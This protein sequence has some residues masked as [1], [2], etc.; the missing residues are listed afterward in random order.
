MAHRHHRIIGRHDGV[1]AEVGLE[2]L[3]RLGVQEALDAPSR[4]FVEADDAAAAVVV[5][6]APIVQERFQDCGWNAALLHAHAGVSGER[7]GAHGTSNRSGFGGNSWRQ[8]T[9]AQAQGV[10]LANPAAAPGKEALKA[11]KNIA[12]PESRAQFARLDQQHGEDMKVRRNAIAVC[13]TAALL[14]VPAA[15]AVHGGA[16][17]VNAPDIKWGDAPPSLPKGAKFTVLSGDPG[18]AGLVHARLQMPAKYKIPAH[19]HSSAEDVT[20]ISGTL[21]LGEGDKLDEKAAHEMKVGAFHSIPPKAHHYAFTKTGAVV[22]I[23]VMGPFDITYIDPKDDPSKAAAPAKDAKAPA[24]D[25][26]K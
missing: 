17:Y 6:F 13:I 11:R 19:W 8:V 25:G 15:W 23:T 2:A 1:G 14:A 20:V 10:S 24:K 7:G 21:Y 12:L 18:K 22:Q 3:E 16:G 5:G 4:A 9:R 26:K